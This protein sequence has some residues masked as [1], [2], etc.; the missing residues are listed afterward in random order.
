MVTPAITSIPPTIIEIRIGSDNSTAA[1]NIPNTGTRL[2]NTAVRA[3]PMALTPC[4]AWD[5]VLPFASPPSK[6]LSHQTMTGQVDIGQH[7]CRKGTTG[8]LAKP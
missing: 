6:H 8:F 5:Q 2:L 3:G 4:R 7:Q 1:N